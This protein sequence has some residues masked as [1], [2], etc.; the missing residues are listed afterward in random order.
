M[1]GRTDISTRSYKMSGEY[2]MAQA[3]LEAEQALIYAEMEYEMEKEQE[4]ENRND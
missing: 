1:S 2:A 3:I 4:D